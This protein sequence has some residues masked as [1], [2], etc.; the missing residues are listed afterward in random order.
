ML[1]N[2]AVTGLV[3]L[4]SLGVAT[5][6][7]AEMFREHAPCPVFEKKVPMTHSWE[8]TTGQWS[9]TYMLTVIGNGLRD[10]KG[11]CMVKIVESQRA[12]VGGQQQGAESV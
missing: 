9:C 1:F 5:P 12:C 7:F 10:A 11:G 8:D 4:G 6:G 2:K 3:V